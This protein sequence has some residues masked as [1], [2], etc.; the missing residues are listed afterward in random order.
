MNKIRKFQIGGYQQPQNVYNALQSGSGSAALLEL[1]GKASDKVLPKWV[2]N[3]M[4][5]F[6][7]LNY[8]AA[9]SHGSINPK[10]GEQ[11]IST[12][13]PNLQLLGRVGEIAYGPKAVKTV[14]RGVRVGTNALK[15]IQIY[16]VPENSMWSSNWNPNKYPLKARGVDPFEEEIISN[17]QRSA[18]NFENP[19]ENAS[20]RAAAIDYVKENPW[21]KWQTNTKVEPGTG[22]DWSYPYDVM[23][24]YGLRKPVTTTNKYTR[25]PVV[26]Q[27]VVEKSI[28][29]Q[30]FAP[31][32]TRRFS[33]QPRFSENWDYQLTPEKMS[34]LEHL[35]SQ[36]NNFSTKESVSKVKRTKQQYGKERYRRKQLDEDENKRLG[37][38]GSGITKEEK[39]LTTGDQRA[40]SPGRKG[41]DN[42][43]KAVVKDAYE[44]A[45]RQA[46][47][48]FKKLSLSIQ[49]SREKL[50]KL[51]DKNSPQAKQIEQSLKQQ[52]RRLVFAVRAHKNEGISGLTKFI[53]EW[54]G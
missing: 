30:T 28:S 4:T 46:I 34:L 27:P 14:G 50:S 3:A 53:K 12:W 16:D 15:R 43:T 26:E 40:I 8:L 29:Q 24:K 18:L 5:Y 10:V 6:S 13:H 49:K 25:Q 39:F 47:D 21:M 41:N 11:E 35:K 31:Y 42:I 17:A 2:Q 52:E 38:T 7:P 48:E 32:P 1:V 33:Q 23:V 51:P 36:M 9:L 22:M 54:K 45:S 44:Y 19:V 37:N 20:A